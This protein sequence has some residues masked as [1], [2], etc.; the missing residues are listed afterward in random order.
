M[1]D[2]FVFD[3]DGVIT[4][5]SKK[6]NTEPEIFD[7]IIEKLKINDPI[8]LNTGRSLTWIKERVINL[9]LA[10]IQNKSI[11][12]NLIAVGEMGGVWLS[13]DDNGKA[14]EYIDNSLSIPK[15]LVE[16]IRKLIEL[17]YSNSMFYDDTKKDNGVNRDE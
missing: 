8:A 10:K 17:K 16:K 15:S 13:F 5:P 9:I 3:I 11:L 4:H 1:K 12:K 2:L 14:N 7:H 6:I